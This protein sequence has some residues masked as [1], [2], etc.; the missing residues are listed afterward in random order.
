M[1]NV[2]DIGLD[3]KVID[4]ELELV[5]QNGIGAMIHFSGVNEQR[6]K[7]V[8]GS[9]QVGDDQSRVVFWGANN[10]DPDERELLISNN[11]I[12][13]QLL[14]TKRNIILG[15]GLM[16]YKDVIKD[17]IRQR[18]EVDMPIAWSDFLE[19]FEVED[20]YL[21]IQAKNL[22]VHAN[23][24]TEFGK[25]KGGS[26]QTFKSHE[27][28]VTRAQVQNKKGFIPYFHI[29]NNW[30]KLNSQQRLEQAAKKIQRIPN[31]RKGENQNKFMT[32]GADKM[33][34]G[35]Y[36]FIPTWE[37][38]RNWI[39]LANCIPEFHLANMKNGFNI[40]FVIYVPEDYYFRSLNDQKRKD[41][42][43]LHKHLKKAKDKF[44]NRINTFLAGLEN[45][46]RALIVTKHMYKQ[47]QKEMPEVRIEPLNY[48]MKDEAML[49]LF[50]SSNTAM[51]SATGTPPALASIAT[52]AKMTSGSEIRNLYNFYQLSQAP[53]YRNVILKD[54]KIALSLYPQQGIK[55]GFRNIEM[56]TT[57][58]NPNGKQPS[59]SFETNPDAA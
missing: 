56:T 50:K 48:D 9:Y 32:H 15:D 34:G 28:R 54:L 11:S 16:A 49:A 2:S 14:A 1:S 42:K 52:D 8:H 59:N 20:E 12:V 17:G 25:N 6:S 24:Y 30:G 31:Y 21:P 33:L 19:Q 37:G 22:V 26:W 39:K 36:Y 23:K 13:T 43:N 4:D 35:P 41:T 47:L 3:S 29:S 7:T 44:K 38:A 46:G 58:K 40:R 27:C 18:E 55:L 45:A 51:T 57:D 10:N 5:V 53:Y